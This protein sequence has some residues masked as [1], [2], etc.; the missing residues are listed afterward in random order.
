MNTM[1]AKKISLQFNRNG[2]QECSRHPAKNFSEK[3]FSLSK[4]ASAMYVESQE[5]FFDGQNGDLVVKAPIEKYISREI[6]KNPDFLQSDM[7]FSQVASLTEIMDENERN[8][9]GK[10]IDEMDVVEQLN[11]FPHLLQDIIAVAT[12]I[13]EL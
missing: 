2:V 5:I 10:T 8:L 9:Y 7:D 6:A 12:P 3:K 13:G 11:T 1:E 4:P